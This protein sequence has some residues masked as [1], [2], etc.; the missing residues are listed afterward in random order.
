AAQSG[1]GNRNEQPGIAPAQFLGSQYQSEIDDFARRCAAATRRSLVASD[2]QLQVAGARGGP[3]R[4]IK[5]PG[6][7]AFPLVELA[8][9]GTHHLL[10]HRVIHA[11]QPGFPRFPL[12]FDQFDSPLTNGR[13]VTTS[14]FL[15]LERL[16]HRVEKESRCAVNDA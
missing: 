2:A 9:E 1:V 8:R 4:F 10:R 5:A 7:F 13:W 12:E 14:I 3:H 6:L 15:W 11:A 16:K